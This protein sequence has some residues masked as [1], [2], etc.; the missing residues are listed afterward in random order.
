[1]NNH[2]ARAAAVKVS[3]AKQ[4]TKQPTQAMHMSQKL[5]SKPISFDSKMTNSMSRYGSY[6][7]SLGQN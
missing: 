6:H 4:P 2:Q 5:A 7:H 3:A 1:M